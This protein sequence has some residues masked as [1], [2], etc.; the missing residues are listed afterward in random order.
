MVF[1]EI[2]QV[3]IVKCKCE[4]CKRFYDVLVNEVGFFVEDIIFDLNVFVVVIGI[5]EYNNYGVDFI[6][7]IGWIKQNL[8]YVMILGGVFNVFF[9]FCGNEFVCEVIYFVFFYYVI[10]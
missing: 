5:E 6:E 4:I 3:D 2:G 10:K 1:D 9:L 8:L 7:V